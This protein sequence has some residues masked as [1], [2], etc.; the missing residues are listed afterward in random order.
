MKLAHYELI[1]GVDLLTYEFISEGTKGSIRKII[2]FSFMGESEFFN[3]GFGDADAE[4][5]EFD[6]M[7]VTDNGDSEKVLATVVSAVYDFLNNFPEAF[8]HAAGSTPTR[9]RLYRMGI[10]KYHKEAETHF[11]IFGKT[12]AGWEP[13]LKGKDYVAFVIRRKGINLEYEKEYRQF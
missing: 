12:Q 7:V 4:T 1:A 9:T 6:D 11:F 10:N 8:V 5:G 2:Q 13:Y 3:L